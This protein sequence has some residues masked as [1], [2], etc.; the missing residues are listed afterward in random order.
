MVVIEKRKETPL[1]INIQGEGIEQ[2]EQFVYIGGLINGD[3]NNKKDIHRR[4]G[5]TSEAFGMMTRIWKN[6]ELLKKI[7]I[8]ISLDG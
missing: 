1:S 8:Q 7:K 3:G 4:I 5:R 6:K 2:V